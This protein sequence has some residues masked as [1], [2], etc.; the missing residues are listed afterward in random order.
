MINALANVNE[1]AHALGYKTIIKKKKSF[2]FIFQ[3]KFY[4]NFQN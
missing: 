1:L 3:K 2:N 4:T